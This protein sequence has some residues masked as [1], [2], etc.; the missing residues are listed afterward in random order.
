MVYRVCDDSHATG[1]CSHHL[2]PQT[3]R[4]RCHP[5]ILFSY[6][7]ENAIHAIARQCYNEYLLFL[8]RRV[9]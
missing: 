8:Y 4:R 5:E 1:L 9:Y 6:R 7:D 3:R 2:T